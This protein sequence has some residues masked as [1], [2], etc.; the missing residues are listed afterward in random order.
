MKR[1]K[2]IGILALLLCLLPIAHAALTD[3]LYAYYAFDNSTDVNSNTSTNNGVNSGTTFVT[4]GILDGAR[5]ATASSG[6][7]INLTFRYDS[8]G[9]N[10]TLNLWLR[11][12]STA[13]YSGL[14]HAFDSQQE[15]LSFESGDNIVFWRNDLRCVMIPSPAGL[16]DNAWHMITL[17]YISATNQSLYK[18][19]TLIN[20]TT[21]C[22]GALSSDYIQ[23]FLDDVGSTR[24]F[25]GTL[26]EIGI[27]NRSLTSTEVTQLY[28]SGA[29]LPYPFS[30]IVTSNL[31]TI[32]VTD[33]YDNSD[34]NGVT[35]DLWNGTDLIT[36]TTDS[37]GNAYF[38]DVGT[39][40]ASVNA[41]FSTY[42]A[43]DTDLSVPVNTTGEIGMTQGILNITSI[44]QLIDG[45]TLGPALGTW[46]I[47]TSGGKTYQ[48]C[49]GTYPC[50][51]YLQD[52]T[53]SL[54]LQYTGAGDYYD[55][56]FQE[57]IT[58]QENITDTITGVY[59]SLI[60][61]TAINGYTGANITNYTLN[62]SNTTEAYTATDTTSTG[63]LLVPAVQG[64]Q[65]L[66]LIDATGYAYENTNITPSS[67][68]ETY[69]F[70]L[71]SNNSISINI[72]DED[73]GLLITEN[74]SITVTGNASEDLYST[75]NGTY[76]LENLT[77]G[78]YTFKFQGGNYTLRT[79]TI[80]VADRSHQTLN[81]FLVL[82]AETVTFN[83]LD[84]ATA[85]SLEGVTTTMSRLINGTWTVVATK[86]SDIT[87]RAQFTYTPTVQYCLASSLTNYD[88]REYCF[89]PIIFES[90]NVRLYRSAT[91]DEDQDY[92][93]VT[94]T[95]NPHLYTNATDSFRIIFGSPQGLLNNYAYT[96]T[97]P[98]NTST[99]NGTTAF[100]QEFNLTIN[101][102]NAVTGDRVNLTYFYNTSIGIQRNFSYSYLIDGTYANQTFAA[103]QDNTYG[104]GLITRILI[105]IIIAIIIAGAA[106][107]AGGP[108]AGGLAGLLVFGY[109]TTIGFMPWWAASIS[110][111]VGTIILMGR[112]GS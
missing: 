82:D 69:Q 105:T 104:L 77:D 6:Q 8:L 76:F 56:N 13:A 2:T 45:A 30:S 22:T 10:F 39:G 55:L 93:G 64:I 59:D 21:T 63:S 28:N 35:I 102:T 67:S 57:S 26:D 46:T 25:S 109:F 94:I 1:A 75:T 50:N 111:L 91:L 5:N 72:F 80:T 3:S 23:A 18:D 52:G 17:V 81:A 47:N 107:I 112:S 70:E 100:G 95:W 90:Y 85:A 41:T 24:T 106:T 84:D 65:L 29:A 97:W 60:N 86:E 11:T 62:S 48:E 53:T 36:N 9:T 103:N 37:N 108:L 61:I 32:H 101:L 4:T 19:G 74:I 54:T 12:P 14:L 79:Y 83:F 110:F 58:A 43:N 42:A 44:T 27:W 15:G 66:L 89:D 73:S 16:K 98:G 88:T 99:E 96:L 49:S 71:Y 40:T 34:L 68:T 31:Y 78:N 38:Y 87:G 92:T 7:Y 33:L 20:T 51:I